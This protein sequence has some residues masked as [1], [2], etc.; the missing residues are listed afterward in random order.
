MKQLLILA[1][2][3]A[4]SHFAFGQNIVLNVGVDTTLFQ[5]I[6]EP[7]DHWISFL[8]TGDD[9]AGIAYWNPEEVEKYGKKY[10]C[11]AETELYFGMDNYL[12]LLSSPTFK[13]TIMSVRQ[14]NEYYK[15]QTLVSMQ[16]ND[17]LS[18]NVMYLFHVYAKETDSGWQLF[19]ALPINTKLRFNNTTVGII[20]Y[21]YPKHH[22]FNPL[23]AQK[24]LAFIDS[25]CKVFDAPM[26]TMDYY[27]TETQEELLKVKGMDY[28][29]GVN[30]IEKP[31]GRGGLNMIMGS[32]CGE[33]YPHES[34]HVFIQP[35]F[36]NMH[37][38]ANEGLAT[39][40][41]G[42]GHNTLDDEVK[43]LKVYLNEHPEVDLDSMLTFINV[44]GIVADYRYVMGGLIVKEVYNKGGIKLLKKFLNAGK[45]NEDYLRAIQECLGVKQKNFNKHFRSLINKHY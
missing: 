18:D 29:M 34:V 43:K 19:N 31:S 27:F 6:K 11:L 21:H 2:F 25:I 15:I 7:L 10:Y 26:D 17:S 41:G 40:L 1:I 33:Y 5:D 8:K 24:Q 12:Q 13:L 45:S 3:I 35:L 39:F 23:L 20:K 14:F 36:P 16:V 22:Q 38:W 44:D 28:V 4:S 42:T 9:D 30:G 37:L 32:G